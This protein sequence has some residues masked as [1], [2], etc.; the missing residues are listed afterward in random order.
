[1]AAYGVAGEKSY[2]HGSMAACE[3][4]HGVAAYQRSENAACMASAKA[5]S[6]SIILSYQQQA[7]SAAYHGVK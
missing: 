7:R 4:Q 2:Q 1:M 6:G 5:Y 3:S